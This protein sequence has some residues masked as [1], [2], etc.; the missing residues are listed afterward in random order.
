MFCVLIGKQKGGVTAIRNTG[1]PGPP[2]TTTTVSK[3]IEKPHSGST[4]DG[5]G[6]LGC[7]EDQ[8]LAFQF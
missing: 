7:Y 2:A 1:V 4:R 3:S 8:V 6:V 5:D